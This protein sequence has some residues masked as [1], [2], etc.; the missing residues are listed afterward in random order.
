MRNRWGRW[1]GYMEELEEAMRVAGQHLEEIERL[2]AKTYE[3]ESWRG[4]KRDSA[5]HEI[6]RRA[7]DVPFLRDLVH[8]SNEIESLDALENA[9]F[10]GRDWNAGEQ[11]LDHRRSC[12]LRPVPRRLLRSNR[13]PS[14]L[15]ASSL[16]NARS[17]IVHARSSSYSII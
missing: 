7:L 15:L 11:Q 12:G 9:G 13:V 4:A 6:V 3:R 14:R 8:V 2:V 17:R 1:H 16:L 10:V 5:N